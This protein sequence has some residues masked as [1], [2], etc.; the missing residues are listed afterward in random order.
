VAELVKAQ[1][2]VQKGSGDFVNFPVLYNP[3]S[4]T[5]T[6]K[7]K[8]AEI[9]IPGLNS[10]LKQ[11]V[12]GESE[13][14][15]VELFFDSTQD[16]PGIEKH[17]VTSL[18]DKFYGLVKIDP[19]THAPPVCAFNWGRRFPGSFLPADPWGNQKR[20]EFV[21]VV[22]EIKQEFKLFDNAGTPRRAVL[23]IQMA[24]YGRLEYQL[25]QL[26][27]QSAEHTRAHVLQQGESLTSVA[28]EHYRNTAAWRRVADANAIEDPRRL[29]PGLTL[30]VPP[31]P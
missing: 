27:L 22:T 3:N 7:P 2:R 14:M 15:R 1:F 29:T 24:E 18:T 6:K 10:P 25:A 30:Q 5:F 16:G 26:N 4:L 21:G 17:S 11:F 13:T 9:P 8:I 23:T 19:A 31:L 28:W 12:R 20:S